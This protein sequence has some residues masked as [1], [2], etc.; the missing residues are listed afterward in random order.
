[1][2]FKLKRLSD[3]EHTWERCKSETTKWKHNQ[4]CSQT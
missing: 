4:I 1:L 3:L 2:Y